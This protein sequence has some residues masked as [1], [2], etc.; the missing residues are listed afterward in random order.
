M[1]EATP[2]VIWNGEVDAQR[3]RV[4]DLGGSA[5]QRLIVEI[6]GL[7]DAMGARGWSRYEPIQRRVFEQMLLQAGLV[8]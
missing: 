8:R 3:Y 4:V 6:Q 2:R 1:A 7:P 5:E